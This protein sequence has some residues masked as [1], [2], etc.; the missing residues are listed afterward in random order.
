MKDHIVLLGFFG[1][2]IYYLVLYFCFIK[3]ACFIFYKEC[4]SLFF[5][6]WLKYDFY[7][8]AWISQSNKIDCLFY[9]VKAGIR[10]LLTDMEIFFLNINIILIWNLILSIV[11]KMSR[12]LKISCS[13]FGCPT[14]FGV[15]SASWSFSREQYWLFLSKKNLQ[16]NNDRFL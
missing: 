11:W 16:A 6:E 4:F 2:I 14:I 7:C 8:N 13:L 12:N 1:Y 3:T 9:F 10:N 15:L 5:H